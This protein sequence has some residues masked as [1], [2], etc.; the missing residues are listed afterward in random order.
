MKY[1]VFK[2]YVETNIVEILYLDYS[3]E[4]AKNIYYNNTH[5]KKALRSTVKYDNDGLEYI[6][7]VENSIRIRLYL[8]DTNEIKMFNL[9]NRMLTLLNKELRKK[10]IEEILK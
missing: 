10:E 1:L 7:Y 5:H 6:F 4:D 8:T 3:L 9:D 2:Y